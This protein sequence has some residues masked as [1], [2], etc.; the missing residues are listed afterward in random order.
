MLPSTANKPCNFDLKN[1]LYCPLQKANC[2]ILT[3]RKTLY[4]PLQQ[5]NPE[6]LTWKITVFK[7]NIDKSIFDLNC[8]LK[9]LGGG[10]KVLNK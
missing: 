8:T 7:T 10:T 3:R 9:E 4:C 1:S 5:T 6:I 2:E